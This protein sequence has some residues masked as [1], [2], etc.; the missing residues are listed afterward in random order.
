MRKIY[1]LL[2]ILIGGLNAIQAEPIDTTIAKQLANRFYRQKANTLVTQRTMPKIAQCAKA[3][4]NIAGTRQTVNRDCYYVVNF[5]NGFVIIAA[6]DR[7]EPILG[8][9]T[10]GAY[11]PEEVPVNMAEWMEGYRQEIAAVLATNRSASAEVSEQWY[12]LKHNINETSRSTV[13]PLLQTTWSQSPYYNQ[14]CPSDPESSSG[15]ALTGCVATAM[16]QVIRYWQYPSVGLG[17]HSYSANNHIYSSSYG[18]YGTLSANF[19]ATTYNYSLMPNSLSNSSTAEQI[20]A[21]ATLLYHCGVSVEMMYGPSASG[22]S[23]TDIPYALEHY[24]AYPAGIQ[25]LSRSSY[26]DNAWSELIKNELNNMRPVV[27]NGH[28]TGGHAFV[29]DGYDGNLFHFNWGWGGY[30]DGYFSLSNLNP[31]AN[32]FNESQGVVTGISAASPYIRCGSNT[33]TI[34]SP[35]GGVSEVEEV[36]VRGHMLSSNISVTVNGHFSVG[37]TAISLGS[38]T[39]LPQDGGT[40]YVQY[41]PTSSVAQTEQGY[42]TLSSGNVHDT[43]LLYGTAHSTLCFAPTNLIPT[44]NASNVTLNWTAPIQ[45]SIAESTTISWDSS[46]NYQFSIGNNQ[47][48]C[49][50]Q[51]FEV[52][53]LS[54]FN[55]HYLNAISF[56]PRAGIT[57]CRIVAYQG[58]SCTP[59]SPY[60]N[61]TP[62][63]QIINQ[64]V[65]LS[66]LNENN[67][68]SIR[69]SNPF[70]IDNTKEL[71]FGVIA[72]VEGGYII[73]TGT[74]TYVAHKGGLIASYSGNY[75]ENETFYFNE[76]SDFSGGQFANNI[77]LKAS[78]EKIVSQVDH[79][80]IYRDHIHLGNV[81]STS[82]VDSITLSNPC[83]YTVYAVNN[84]Y[85]TSE[86][87]IT[88]YPTIP[89]LPSVIIGEMVQ[90][91][92]TSIHCNGTVTHNGNSNLS[93]RGFCWSSSHNPTISDD[94]I[95][96]GNGMGNFS[97]DPTGLTPGNTYYVRS[98]ATNDIGTNYSDEQSITLYFVVPLSGTESYTVSSNSVLVYDNGG[99]DNNYSDNNGGNLILYAGGADYTFEITGTYDIENP[100]NE[101]YYDELYIYDGASSSTVL[102]HLAGNSTISTPITSTQNAIRIYFKSDYSV[103]HSGFRLIVNRI[104][105]ASAP[106][107]TTAEI[108]NIQAT[109]VTGGGNVTADNGAAVTARGVCWSITPNPT[110]GGI[111]CNH[112]SD[113][114]GTGAFTSSI[115]GLTPNTTYYVRAYATNSVGTSYGEP[116][117]FKTSCNSV[118]AT[119]T[120]N[121]TICHGDSTTLSANSSTS[122][123]WSNHSVEKSITVS[124]STS[125]TYSV[126]IINE[127]GCTASTS[128]PVIVNSTY[129]VNDFKSA[130][131]SE[132]PIL[133]NGVEFINAG[134]QTNTLQTVNGC[135]SIVTMTLAIHNG[136][137]NVTTVTECESYTWTAGTG[138]TYTQSGTYVHQYNNAEGCPS[139]DTLRLTI[140]NGTHN[141]ATVTECESYTWTAGTG[142]TYTQS[143]TYIHKYNN[144]EGCPSADTLHLTIHD[145]T[146]NVT[147]VT[148]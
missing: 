7:V 35:V 68:N 16:A 47:T 29:C 54:Q 17:S 2:L 49:M 145:G 46:M 106:A 4:I 13:A 132:L 31:G 101:N 103:N 108:T 6:D 48:Y 118:I 58:G 42:I 100:Y 74:A 1:L 77:L 43:I 111:G 81:T 56:I 50:L 140:L 147:T 66:E 24:F 22:A 127:Y 64:E 62:G 96:A 129:H 109:T 136:T 119:I 87:S 121:N 19:G 37:N 3:Q 131:A 5:D 28:G 115:T 18:D 38:S 79:Y 70:I 34:F 148:E 55:Q 91:N 82:Y 88:A 93:E 98:Y 110:V 26:S 90:E 92:N 52:S 117:T 84:N 107:V 78:I 123:L 75:N 102:A 60:Y 120:G 27:Y 139:A 14:Y 80:E 76:M 105:S 57:H 53:D 113:G 63:E 12:K 114:S 51:R 146:H 44:I 99:P 61:F 36:E 8:Y 128:F 69:L 116:K 112:T 97:A 11:N 143:G 73:N 134:T 15:H 20:D 135:D 9:S 32:N 33:L 10:S 41:L 45:N 126:T 137:H 71:W 59:G 122:Y 141:V 72:C 85:C 21:V 65:S 67:W 83:Q 104:G 133:W 124:P 142:L 25:Y 125:T 95:S 86:A 130:C 39:T 40:L 30:A 138:L 89:C 144:A 23:T 94:H